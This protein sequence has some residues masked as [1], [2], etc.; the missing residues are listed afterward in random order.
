MLGARTGSF[1]G[2]QIAFA[3]RLSFNWDVNSDQTTQVRGGIGVFTS[4]IPLVWPGG[5]YNNFGFNIGETSRRN[6]DF[7]C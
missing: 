1:I 3:P 2:T 4:R 5:A 6:V 7:I